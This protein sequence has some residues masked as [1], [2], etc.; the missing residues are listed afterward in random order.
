MASNNAAACAGSLQGSGGSL[1]AMSTRWQE[2][3]TA[4]TAE[5]GAGGAAPRI[6]I[7]CV[8]DVPPEAAALASTHQFRAKPGQ[9]LL[10][11][12]PEVW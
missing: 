6:P 9:L 8:H 11:P 1:S 7:R 4:T 3:F 10:I 12:G 5:E 2:A